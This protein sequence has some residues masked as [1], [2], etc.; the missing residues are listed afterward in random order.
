MSC[1]FQKQQIRCFFCKRP[2]DVIW[3]H[4]QKTLFLVG[5][6]GAVEGIFI[7]VGRRGFKIP[8]LCKLC[9]SSG[10]AG[11]LTPRGAGP[12]HVAGAKA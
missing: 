2:I 11:A 5:G 6:A 3:K 7:N 1:I 8:V 9:A 12:G 10:A 4:S